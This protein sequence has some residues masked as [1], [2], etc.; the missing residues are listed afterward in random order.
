MPTN[1]VQYKFAVFPAQ[2]RIV[3]NFV[4]AIVQHEIVLPL[5]QKHSIGPF[6]FATV[7]RKKRDWTCFFCQFQFSCTLNWILYEWDSLWAY[8]MHMHYG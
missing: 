2:M 7:G 4:V 8:T 3:Y 5:S 6:L 1:S